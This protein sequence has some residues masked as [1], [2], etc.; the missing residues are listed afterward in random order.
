MNGNFPILFWHSCFSS[1]TDTFSIEKLK[2]YA[3]LCEI[4]LPEFLGF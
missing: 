3:S 1:L 4:A 2:F